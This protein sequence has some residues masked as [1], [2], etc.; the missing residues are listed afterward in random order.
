M[1]KCDPGMRRLGRDCGEGGEVGGGCSTQTHGS[2]EHIL[3][4]K[5]VTVYPFPCRVFISHGLA[6]DSRIDHSLRPA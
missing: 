4:N 3:T 6:G 5:G 2:R 1:D